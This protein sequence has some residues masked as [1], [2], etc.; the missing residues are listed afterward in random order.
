MKDGEGKRAR[1]RSFSIVAHIGS[2]RP[3]ARIK[4]TS[5]RP[6]LGARRLVAV[7]GAR[8]T[9]AGAFIMTVIN[10]NISALTAQSGQRIAGKGLMMAMERLSTGLRINSAKDDAAGLAISQRM[11]AELRGLKVA[12]RNAQDG[13]S[14]AQTAESAMSSVSN[15]LQRMRE[16]SVQSANGIY[17]ATDRAAL[18]V[19]VKQLIDEIDT[20]ASRTNFNGIKRLGGS[21]KSLLVQTGSRAGETVRLGIGSARAGSLGTGRTPA[22]TGTGAFEATSTNLPANQAMQAGDLVINGVTIGS[23]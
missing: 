11:T 14:L 2:C 12:S 4:Q 22:L 1:I 21:A 10:T 9:E 13:I 18:Q 5:P 15:S 6:Y 20:V 8:G 7:H 3:T 23:S 19:E 16:L 17:S